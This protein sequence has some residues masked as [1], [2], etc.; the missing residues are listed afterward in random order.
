MH[1]CWRYSSRDHITPRSLKALL[2]GVKGGLCR[3]RI[4]K[5]TADSCSCIVMQPYIWKVLRITPIED[6]PV[7]RRRL[8]L[9]FVHRRS[10][11]A[12]YLYR[13]QITV[14]CI[15]QFSH[16]GFVH[17]KSLHVLASMKTAL[18]TAFKRSVSRLKVSTEDGAV[19]GFLL[20][21]QSHLMA[22]MPKEITSLFLH[23][24]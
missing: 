24:K 1:G 18:Y 7:G 23:L 16:Q 20:K 17:R 3:K 5:L 14:R 9:I 2:K 12:M 22:R 19:K 8:S 21:K 11:L 15:V 6:S 13:N 4:N 10:T